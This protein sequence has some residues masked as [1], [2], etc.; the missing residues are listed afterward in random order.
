MATVHVGIGNSDGKLSHAEWAEFWKL[1]NELLTEVGVTSQVYGVWHSLPARPYVNA[2][3]AVEV[4]DE[5][6]DAV[7]AALRLLG[8]RY[9]Q[10]SIAWLEG[11]TE[12]LEPA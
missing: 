7:R 3:W 2:C 10:D 1:T 9:G 4:P 5:H 6:R 12:F 11:T 8:G